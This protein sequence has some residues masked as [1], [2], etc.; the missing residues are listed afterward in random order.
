MNNKTPTVS[1][2]DPTI[3]VKEMIDD[4]VERIDDLRKT[5]VRRIDEKIDANDVKYQIQFSSAKEA[6]AIA[7]TAQEKSMTASFEGTKDAINKADVNTDKRFEA[8]SQ[9]IDGVSELLNKNAGAQGIYVTHNDLNVEMEKLR[10]SFEAMLRPVVTFMNSQT[11]KT[12]GVDMSWSRAAMV[13]AAA[14]T[15]ITLLVK[16]IE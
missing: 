11:G 5:E 7:S 6:V 8:I 9:K 2:P 3:N 4:A 16:F 1:K 15:I 12:Q 10:V 13:I 14:A